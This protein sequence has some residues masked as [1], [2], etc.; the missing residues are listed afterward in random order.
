MT[1]R[2]AKTA[3]I[4]GTLVLG[5]TG[6]QAASTT[7]TAKAKI[8]QQVAVTNT[9]DLD[10]GTIV[11]GTAASTVAIG[12]TGT[13]TCGAGLTCSGSTAAA[14]FSVLGTIGQTVTISTTNAT[15][16]SGTNNMSTALTPSQATMVL[17]ATNAFTVGGTLNVG[18]NQADGNYAGTFSVTVNYQ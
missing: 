2:F 1:N 17:A 16:A 6:A 5:A 7:A 14:G 18:A 13:R 12:S 8:L 4:L 11:T 9:S 10:F 3:I 15:L